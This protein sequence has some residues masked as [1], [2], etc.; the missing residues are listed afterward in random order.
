MSWPTW[1][2]CGLLFAIVLIL[3]DIFNAIV[4]L[5]ELQKKIFDHQYKAAERINDTV[6]NSAGRVVERLPEKPKE[7]KPSA[8][9]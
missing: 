8:W 2:L 5:I 4:A 6:W 3:R 9:D 7:Y 1:I